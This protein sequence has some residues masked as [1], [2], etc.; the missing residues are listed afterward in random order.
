VH[1]DS[2]NGHLGLNL[3]PGGGLMALGTSP[4]ISACNRFR[5][6]GSGIGADVISA[7]VYGCLGLVTTVL[8]GPYSTSEPAYITAMVSDMY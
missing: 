8:V 6:S 4:L 5:R 7:I 3:H 2:A 1:T